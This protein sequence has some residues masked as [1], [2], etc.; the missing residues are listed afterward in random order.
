MPHDMALA[1]YRGAVAV[2]LRL[3]G[4][5]YEELAATLGYTH[6]SA[7]RKA[8][9]RTIKAR[10]DMVVDAYRV[11]RYLELE[12]QHNRAWVDALSGRPQA[13]KSCLKAAD[14]RLLLNGVA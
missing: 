2:Q 12:E 4:H 1:R 6:R 7:A 9:M 13:T 3:E 14:E 11:H 5:T 10:A 8:V